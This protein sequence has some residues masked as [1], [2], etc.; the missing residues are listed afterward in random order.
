MQCPLC[1]GS[2]ISPLPHIPANGGLPSTIYSVSDANCGGCEGRG[3]LKGGSGAEKEFLG[4][5]MAYDEKNKTASV[6][7]EGALRTGERIVV[8]MEAKTLELEVEVIQ[9]GKAWVHLARRGWTI[10]I[11]APMQVGSGAKI[12]RAAG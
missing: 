11:P 9:W 12:Y 6:R 1:N 2:G 8:V 5:V 10:T 3:Y 4:L 7:L